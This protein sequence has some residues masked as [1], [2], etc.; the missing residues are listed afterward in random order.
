[1]ASI[2]LETQAVVLQL[3]LVGMTVIVAGDNVESTC[4]I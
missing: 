2:V 3:L 1:M 4:V